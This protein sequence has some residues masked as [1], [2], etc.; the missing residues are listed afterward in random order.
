MKTTIACVHRDGR[1]V[2]ERLVERRQCV[3]GGLLPSK[4][5]G[6]ALT[7]RMIGIVGKE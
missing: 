6:R 1:G 2:V 4:G 5:G 3:A 7:G